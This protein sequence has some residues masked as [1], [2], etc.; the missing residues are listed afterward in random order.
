M[1]YY[2]I[3]KVQGQP[4]IFGSGNTNRT[5]K[6]AGTY[7]AKKFGVPTKIVTTLPAKA[8]WFT[9]LPE[10]TRSFGLPQGSVGI[11]PSGDNL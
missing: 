10:P 11:L 2:M 8:V 5:A 1:N 7:N 4:V 6:A 9:T 3:G